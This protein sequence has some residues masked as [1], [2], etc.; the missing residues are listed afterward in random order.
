MINCT[1][2]GGP[3]A[4]DLTYHYSPVS[5]IT[6]IEDSRPSMGQT[7]GY[8][9]LDRLTRQATALVDR[10]NDQSESEQR[11]AAPA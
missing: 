5:H 2:S 6:A 9:T 11:A 1:A 10:I 7:F 4:I 8:D 3:S